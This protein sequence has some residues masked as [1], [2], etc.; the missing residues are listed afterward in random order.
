MQRSDLR[1]TV[2]DID[3]AARGVGERIPY[4]RDMNP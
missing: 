2:N 4:I 1:K 3:D